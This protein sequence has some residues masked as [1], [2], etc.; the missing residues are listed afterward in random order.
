[1]PEYVYIIEEYGEIDYDRG[2]LS[3]L[4]YLDETEAIKTWR[5]LVQQ[6][7]EDSSYTLYRY[8]PAVFPYRDGWRQ[9]YA[10]GAWS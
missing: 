1:M 7:D 5:R 3:Y 10:A 6:N 8:N 9:V 4:P 2:I